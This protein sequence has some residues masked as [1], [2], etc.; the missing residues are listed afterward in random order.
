M[1]KGQYMRNILC[2]GFCTESFKFK[3]Y[4]SF[5]KNSQMAA[6]KLESRYI[7]GL[8]E[9]GC[10][11][12][13]ISSF[14]ASTY[15]GNK[16]IFFEFYSKIISE[17][18]K[19]FGAGFINLPG[20]KLLTR[21]FSVLILLFPIFTKNRTRPNFIV[22][23]SLHQP[24]VIVG[25]ILKFLFRKKVYVIV[26]DLPMFMRTGSRSNVIVSWL[27]YFDEILLRQGSSLFDGAT[28][29]CDSMREKLPVL[30]K[31]S[32]IVDGIVDRSA[33]EKYLDTRSGLG[34]FE[35]KKI[36]LYTGQLVE[37]Y[38]VLLLLRA[39]DYLPSDYE[40]WIAGAGELT[41]EV[42]QASKQC[43]RLRYLGLLT[44]AEVTSAYDSA[45]LLINPRLLDSEFVK[46]SF[47]SKLLEYLTSGV[48]VLTSR[49]PSIQEDLIPFLGFIDELTPVGIARAVQKICSDQYEDAIS[50]AAHARNY[51]NES[52][53][54][55]AQAQR[56]LS[57]MDN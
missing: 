23:Y 13:S 11:I 16:K 1:L 50:R 39:M 40:I 19:I 29:I 53:S 56:F 26:P 15:P 38:G 6:Q 57:I 10:T 49:L 43:H 24:Y 41:S 4:S 14:P 31:N 22:I 47:P 35:S 9:S 42:E 20:L 52:R 37:S 55:I 3:E 44:S 12:N 25:L 17:H 51:V 34:S 48:P 2:I 54:P 7:N 32:I 45:T 5:D 28:F 36:I 30:A 18:H 27:K 33:S 8:I 46:F 21:L